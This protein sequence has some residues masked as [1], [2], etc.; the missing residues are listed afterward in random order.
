MAFAESLKYVGRLF[1][2]ESGAGTSVARLRME[3]VGAK[4]KDRAVWRRGGACRQRKRE[5][6]DAIMR[7]SGSLE[8]GEG[9]EG[10]G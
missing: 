10:R 7:V 2:A 6:E 8:V 1:A 3:A 4:V 9:S 5:A